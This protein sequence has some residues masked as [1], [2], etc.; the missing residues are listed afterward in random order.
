MLIH[1]Y[2]GGVIAAALPIEVVFFF[3]FIIEIIVGV[4]VIN[5]AGFLRRDDII[6]S[7]DGS[8]EQFKQL[9]EERLATIEP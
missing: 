4:I 9:A 8:E 3:I 1:P 6:C 2:I 5:L 7:A